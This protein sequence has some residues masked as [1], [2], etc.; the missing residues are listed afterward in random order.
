[1]PVND[2]LQSPAEEHKSPAVSLDVGDVSLAAVNM[3]AIKEYSES[4]KAAARE[5]TESQKLVALALTDAQSKLT[6]ITTAVTQ[7]VAAMTKVVDDQAV[8]ATKSDHI[9]NAQVHADGVRANLD[10]TLTGA[11]QQ[12]TEAEGLKARTQAAAD[13]AAQLLTE[14]RTTKGTVEADA[15][16]V[17]AALQA[18]EESADV[19]KGL[20]DKSATIETRIADYE[21]QLADLK[22]QCANQLRT[23]EGLLPGAA[24]AGLAH[25]FDER[26]Q[27]FLAPRRNW[28]KWYV[29]SMAL[30]AV[31]AVVNW[32]QA[33]HGSVSPT[34][35][36]SLL[37]WLVRLPVAAPF[38]WL[39]IHSSHEAA[40]AKR[41]EEDYGYKVAVA[42]SFMGFHKQMT[43]VGSAAS[44]N[45]PLAKLCNDTLSTIASPPGRIYEKHKLTVSPSRELKEAAETLVAFVKAG[46]KPTS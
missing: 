3:A 27:T 33:Y 25:A 22:G 30:I 32:W 23:I 20:A 46:I 7:A 19:A 24:S 42:S 13:N 12:A 18:A 5:A 39:A 21:G 16:A 17:A 36:E 4:A 31:L 40:L 41:L 38:I 29:A 26:R 14:V 2:D 10:R 37:L 34:W 28:E 9:Q 45:A 44:S 43:E 11:T 35:D 6:E 15:G 1:M 8:I